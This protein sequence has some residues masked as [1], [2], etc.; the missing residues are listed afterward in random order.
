MIDLTLYPLIGFFIIT[1]FVFYPKLRLRFSSKFLPLSDIVLIGISQLILSL[2]VL[3]LCGWFHWWLAIALYLALTEFSLLLYLPR[4]SSLQTVKE[5][6]QY[7]DFARTCLFFLITLLVF[8]S[9]YGI[10]FSSDSYGK[11]LGRGRIL[12][13]NFYHP[14]VNLKTLEYSRNSQAPVSYLTT[15]LVFQ[16]FKSDA[17][18]ARGIPIFFSVMTVWFILLWGGGVAG[19]VGGKVA[20]FFLC[21]SYWY[22]KSSL[23]VMQEAPLIFF[24]TAMFMKFR[25][26]ERE[27]Q[28]IHLL[29]ALVSCCLAILSKESALVLGLLLAPFLLYGLIQLE[30]A[31]V[32]LV[33]LMF[34]ASLP[35][36]LWWGHNLYHWGNPVFPFLNSIFPGPLQEVWR[37][38]F[39]QFQSILPEIQVSSTRFMKLLGATFP[40]FWLALW[41]I[42]KSRNQK[43]TWFFLSSI[44]ITGLYFY[45]WGGRWLVRY[46]VFFVGPYSVFALIGLKSIFPSI[47]VKEFGGFLATS[48]TVV[49]FVIWGVYL[50]RM[51]DY[52]LAKKAEFELLNWVKQ[53][54][55]ELRGSRVLGDDAIPLVN[56]YLDP[57]DEIE[58]YRFH[59]PKFLIQHEGAFSANMDAEALKLLLQE[60]DFGFILKGNRKNLNSDFYNTVASDSKSFK[61]TYNKKGI[62]IWKVISN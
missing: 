23:M 27:R 38:S 49:V 26:W 62:R 18:I 35:L 10:R 36:I 44:V 20:V 15:G 22:L 39:S 46:L 9:L 48:A 33:L 5:D 31:R 21:C 56:W 55:S 4:Q 7:Y 1:T 53:D 29:L 24:T 58:V 57:H 40:F 34:W 43:T 60:K 19:R 45:F 2:E 8:S 51:P 52:F 28:P 16:F 47:K 41:G 32:R 17:L 12:A 13:E 3:A 61:L 50:Y 14:P 59:E 11:F 25:Q 42:W 6:D 30:S 37:A 54:G